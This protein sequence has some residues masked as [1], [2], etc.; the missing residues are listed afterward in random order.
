METSEYPGRRISTRAPTLP[1]YAAM[2]PTS[3]LKTAFPPGAGLSRSHATRTR[4]VSPSSDG[5]MREK[6][7]GEALTAG[8]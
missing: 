4:L 6:E 1:V 5:T 3:L 2:R 8:V 7:N